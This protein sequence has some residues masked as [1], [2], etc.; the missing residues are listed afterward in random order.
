MSLWISLSQQIPSYGE[1]VEVFDVNDGSLHRKTMMSRTL[2]LGFTLDCNS[3]TT[4]EEKLTFI[5]YTLSFLRD[6]VLVLKPDDDDDGDDGEMMTTPTETRTNWAK[7]QLKNNWVMVLLNLDVFVASAEGQEAPEAE[8]ILSLKSEG[9]GGT[10]PIQAH[11]G[12]QA[13]WKPVEEMRKCT[14]SEPLLWL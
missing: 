3:Q 9:T 7:Q 8:S 6:A 13:R 4:N 5:M 11:W 10:Q 1:G 14:W 12:R 2:G